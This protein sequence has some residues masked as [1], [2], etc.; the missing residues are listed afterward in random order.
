MSARIPDNMLLS[1]LLKA[2]GYDCPQRLQGKTFD[3]STAGEGNISIEANKEVTISENGTV[4]VSPSEGKDLMK[5]VTVNVNIPTL[6]E[7]LRYFDGRNSGILNAPKCFFVIGKHQTT[8]K[9][10]VMVLEPGATTHCV[11]QEVIEVTSTTLK[12]GGAYNKI[13]PEVTADV[14]SKALAVL[15]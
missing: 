9:T 6:S 1:D 8:G 11:P 7:D 15:K 13:F 4:V 2:T 10:S 12:V 3:E 5:K 14:V